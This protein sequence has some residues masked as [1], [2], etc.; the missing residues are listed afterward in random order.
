MKKAGH[1]GY[2]K[3][4]IHDEGQAE[5]VTSFSERSELPSCRGARQVRLLGFGM[6]DEGETRD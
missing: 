2:R 3:R 6:I 4:N 1:F 5:H